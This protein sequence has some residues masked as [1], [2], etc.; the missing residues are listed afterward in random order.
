MAEKYLALDGVKVLIDIMNEK[1][2]VV[3]QAIPTDNNQLGNGAGYITAEALNDYAKKS[4]IPEEAI[5]YDDTEL[6]NRIETLEAIDHNQYAT[7]TEIP[8]IESLTEE[9]IR[10]LLK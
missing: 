8:T 10:G 2:I 4:E 1:D 9:D 6:K 7:K 5:P 3:K